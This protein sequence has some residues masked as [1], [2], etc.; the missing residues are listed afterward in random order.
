MV[1]TFHYTFDELEIV[2]ANIVELLGFESGEI[3]EPFPEL[4]GKALSEAPEFCSIRGGYAIFDNI[5]IN[6]LNGTL[7]INDQCFSPSEIV[8][9]QFSN[10]A[11]LAVFVG[12]AGEKISKYAKNLAN[13][14]DPMSSYIFDVIGSVAV[15]K[16]M[17]KIKKAMEESVGEKGLSISDSFSPGYCEWDVAEQQLLFSLLPENFCGVSLSPSSLMHPIKSV[18][19]IIAIGHGLKQKGYQCHWCNDKTCLYGK[20]KRN[21][22]E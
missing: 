11:K 21:K 12:T 7:R 22:K 15:E 3:P 13:N 6:P 8:L 1:H 16:A 19:G 9:T 4:I 2:P 10:A 5:E 14:G 18:S 17:G 20:V